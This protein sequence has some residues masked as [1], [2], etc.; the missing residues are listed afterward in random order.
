MTFEEWIREYYPEAE[1]G[2]PLI[3]EAFEAG[4]ASIRAE[5]EAR[6]DRLLKEF[7]LNNDDRLTIL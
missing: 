3:R 1:N 5:A 4:K 6:I 2:N 7:V